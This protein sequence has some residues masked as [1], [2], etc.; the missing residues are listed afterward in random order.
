MPADTQAGLEAALRVG[1]INLAKSCNGLGEYFVDLVEGLASAGIEQHV[2][3]RHDA[4]AKRL[5]LI[6]SVNVGPTVGS[7]VMAY[8]LMPAVDVVHIHDPADGQAGLLM[9]LTRSIPYVLTRRSETPSQGTIA[10]AVLRRAAGFVF[11]G[12]ADIDKHRRLYRQAVA[13]RRRGMLSV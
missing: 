6:D 7:A 11:L 5:A 3:V 8:C 9:T 10:G 12:D 13:Q 2:I 4:I 1:H